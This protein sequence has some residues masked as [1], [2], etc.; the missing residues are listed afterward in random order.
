MTAQN[1]EGEAK[2]GVGIHRYAPH[3]QDWLPGDPTWQA[4]KGKS[5]IGAVNYLADMGLN[6]IYFLT[7]NINGDSK[8][9]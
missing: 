4:D 9:V 8:D 5:I 2:S 6:S 7:L 1:R 3:L